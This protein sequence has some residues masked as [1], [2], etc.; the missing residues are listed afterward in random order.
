MARFKDRT[1]CMERGMTGPLSK[2][3]WAGQGPKSSLKP[4]MCSQLCG[5]LLI[6]STMV[7]LGVLSVLSF[8]ITHIEFGF[9]EF[10]NVS[11]NYQL[12]HHSL[13]TFF[14][15]GFFSLS[16]PQWSSSST[17]IFGVAVA[18]SVRSV[19]AS[20]PAAAQISPQSSL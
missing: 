7:H 2:T 11:T 19:R 12:V 13:P 17:S 8:R 18:Q 16:F 14:Y 20:N 5:L 10:S 3:G 15:F 4:F 6:Q 9:L 1:V